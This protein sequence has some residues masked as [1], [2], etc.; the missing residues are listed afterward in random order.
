MALH[1]ERVTA[2]DEETLEALNALLPQ[3]SQ[4]APPLTLTGFAELVA[5]EAVSLFVARDGARILGTTTLVAF[6]IP[7]GR[8][9]WIEDVVVD[10]SA[11]GQG[12]GEALVAAAL[13][14]ARALGA[15]TVDLTSR[16]SRTAAHALYQRMGFEV[17]ETNVYR[18]S[19]AE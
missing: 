7:T 4:S 12:V 5:A 6:P 3:L 19:L 2:A 9:A 14:R 13:E 1:V 11:R 16:A 10:E 15:R 8:R 17:R 18:I